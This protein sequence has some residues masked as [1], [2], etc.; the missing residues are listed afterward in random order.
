M[1]RAPTSG[2]CWQEKK[3]P[4]PPDSRLSP[5]PPPPLSS[6]GKRDGDAG[7]RAR[8]TVEPG[9]DLPCRESDTPERPD[10]SVASQPG[11]LT[12]TTRSRNRK[13][14]VRLA[15]PSLF[16]TEPAVPTLHN[17]GRTT[18]PPYYLSRCGGVFR[19]GT[20][21]NGTLASAAARAS[22]S[23]ATP[24]RTP[25]AQ[26]RRRPIMAIGGAEAGNG[27]GGGGGGGAGDDGRARRSV[28]VTGG[29]GFIG[30]H[31]VLRLL[32]Q[33]Y[34][35]TVVDNFH[36]SVPEALDRVRLIAG[37]A[38]SARLDFILA[39]IHSLAR[40]R[41]G[42]L[43]SIDDLEKVFAAKRYA[44]AKRKLLL[45]SV[46]AR[47]DAVVHFAG[48]KAV[49]ESVAHPDMYYENN[50][51]GTINLYKTMKK[52]GCMKMVFS[53]SAT[54]YG[55]P[56]VIP[57]VEDAKLQA[58]NPYGRTKVTK[59]TRSPR[60]PVETAN[61]VSRAC[62]VVHLILEDLAR[63]Y[64]RADPE[65]GIVL[66][67]YFN[68]IGAHSSGEIGEDPKG[69]PNNLLPY[70]QQVA[71]GRLAELNVYGHDY[72]TR[73]GTAIRDYIHVVDLADG[74][75]AA[76]NKLFDT[77]DIGRGTSVLEMV[78]AFKKASGKVLS[79]HGSGPKLT[80]LAAK[81]QEIPTKFCPRRPGDA[82]EVYASTE[83]AERELGWRAQY[84]IEEMC[85]DQW[86]WAKKNPYG[87]CGTFLHRSYP[88]SIGS[89]SLT[90]PPATDVSVALRLLCLKYGTGTATL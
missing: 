13:T 25:R 38:L 68:P 49:G 15:S 27:G 64:Q 22:A 84:G 83:K 36:N 65:W 33:G 12:A 72:P 29:A 71:V 80:F 62:A 47:Y 11:R 63:D 31:T 61:R 85:R 34:G 73:D 24:N 74:H 53:S 75:I 7:D 45:S 14:T 35:V 77:P 87:Y 54:V 78:A 40:L 43:R 2:G 21:P 66:L 10:P 41:D 76:L 42:D 88:L 44:L 79:A 86:N 50:L 20:R 18:R 55:W 37:P 89:R 51:V 60:R 6:L 16:K 32:E 30:T 4:A 57:C 39:L 59:K 5:P 19:D 26:R 23:T 8:N 3:H 70:I 9:E 28:L 90:S 67:R 52:H 46:S 56:E 17:N 69:I 1:T 82:T 81:L 48:L 58:A